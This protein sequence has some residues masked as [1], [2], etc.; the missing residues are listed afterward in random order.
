MHDWFPG[1]AK[2]VNDLCRKFD[3]IVGIDIAAGESH[4]KTCELST[5]G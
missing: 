5:V 3:S 4:F 2:E 1:Q